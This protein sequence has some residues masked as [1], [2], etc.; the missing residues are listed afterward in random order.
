MN[1][2]ERK[3]VDKL[4]FYI[5]LDKIRFCFFALGSVIDLF[6]I[7]FMIIQFAR[8]NKDL[9]MPQ[10]VIFT[11]MAFVQFI[12]LPFLV[13]SEILS[14]YYRNKY[15]IDYMYKHGIERAYADYEDCLNLIYTIYEYYLILFIPVCQTV[16]TFNRVT[17]LWNPI[18]HKLFWTRNT[19]FFIILIMLTLPLIGVVQVFLPTFTVPNQNWGNWTRN[20]GFL[21]CV[22]SVVMALLGECRNVQIANSYMTRER[23]SAEKKLLIAVIFANIGGCIL[24]LFKILQQYYFQYATRYT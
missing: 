21:L 1:H 18:K 12:R 23:A 20:V 9:C 13:A 8:R 19:T 2:I 7:L 24:F 5:K 15:G 3:I 4:L 22:L 14:I 16:I 11:I 17:I 6:F 10:Y